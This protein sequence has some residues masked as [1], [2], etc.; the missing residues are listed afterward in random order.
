MA[1]HE[2]QRHH[3]KQLL[4]THRIAF[5]LHGDQFGEQVVARL[6]AFPGQGL[7]EVLV[8]AGATLNGLVDLLGGHERF[9]GLDQ[10]LG[11]GAEPDHVGI[12]EAEH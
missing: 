4:F 6:T 7:P 1:G 8:H 3:G 2:Q 12:G 9:Q 5:L 11:P 10:G